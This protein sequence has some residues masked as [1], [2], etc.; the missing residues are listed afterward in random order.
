MPSPCDP[1]PPPPP[2]APFPSII[3]SWPGDSSS[4]WPPLEETVVVVV[5][6]EALWAASWE[7]E[8]VQP[9]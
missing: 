9:G 3:S 6:G 1:D 2:P 8:E 5:S 7:V 4:A